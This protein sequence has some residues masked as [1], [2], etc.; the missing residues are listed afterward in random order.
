VPDYAKAP[1][2]LSGLVLASSGA[3]QASLASDAKLRAILGADPTT[4]R[5]FARRDTLTAYVEAYTDAK[6][7]V[8][9]VAVT[10]TITTGQGAKVRSEP[11]ARGASEAG[12]AAF[13]V[14]LPLADLAPGDYVLTIDAKTGKR[15]A[16]RQVGF[17]VSP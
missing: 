7:R 2:T 16:T 4:D 11:I 5:R 12:R 13:T 9:D 15:T 1:L 10:A 6:N 3:P 14:R 17:V 8:E